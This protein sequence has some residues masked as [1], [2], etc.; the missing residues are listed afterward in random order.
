MTYLVPAFPS[1]RFPPR[2]PLGHDTL[3]RRDE[4]KEPDLERLG[5]ETNGITN[6][7]GQYLP[8]WDVGCGVKGRGT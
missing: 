7:V 1:L 4:S 2:K 5:S 8:G 3:E 6:H